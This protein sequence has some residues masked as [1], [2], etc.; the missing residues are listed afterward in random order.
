MGRKNRN[1]RPYRAGQTYPSVQAAKQDMIHFDLSKGEC[2]EKT[3]RSIRGIRSDVYVGIGKNTNSSI[4]PFV[5][6]I[7]VSKDHKKKLGGHIVARRIVEHGMERLYLLEAEPEFGYKLA[8]SSSGYR[9][10]V[11]MMLT[12]EDVHKYEG[13][14][15]SHDL[16]YDN[17][18]DAYY[19]TKESER[20]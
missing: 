16:E 4:K 1:A 13:Y 10:Q 8:E 11:K 17:Y 7:S 14:K 5:L 12:A 2:I 18:N 19:I 20:S 3:R 15:G 9:S 6:C